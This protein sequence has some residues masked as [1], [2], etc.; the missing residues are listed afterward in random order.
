M[1]AYMRFDFTTLILLT[2]M[3]LINSNCHL[4][5]FA[6]RKIEFKFNFD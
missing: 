4:R 1:P 6:D 5:G 3:G 2:P